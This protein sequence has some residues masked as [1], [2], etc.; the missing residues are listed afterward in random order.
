[1][2]ITLLNKR[3]SCA[4]IEAR[5]RALKKRFP[6][7]L[8]ASVIGHSHDNRNIYALI[9]GSGEKTLI[10]AAGIHGRETVNPVVFLKIIEQYATGCVRNQTLFQTPIR[11]FFKEYAIC[12]IPLANPDGYAIATEGFEKLQDPRLRKSAMSLGIPSSEWKYNGL[13]VDI[14]RNFSCKSY[15]KTGESG[16]PDSEPETRAL[17][18]VFSHCQSIGF[19]DFHS[20]G[21]MIYCHRG[22]MPE[23]YNKRQLEIARALQTHCGYGIGGPEEELPGPHSGGNSVH[24]YSE[25]VKQPALTIET[26]ND[27]ALFPLSA[28]HYQ[29]TM[30][31]IFKLP[32]AYLDWHRRQG[33]NSQARPPQK[34][35]T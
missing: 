24:H 3:Y 9:I 10:C 12:F 31:E 35:A 33:S 2:N 25:T 27:A 5:A 22:V 15:E 32:L 23:A 18:H 6:T 13:G 21:R 7:L 8:K 26:V 28:A 29:P 34:A 30:Q 14:N 4:G 19:L 1:M 20:R 17:L 16:Q 11:H